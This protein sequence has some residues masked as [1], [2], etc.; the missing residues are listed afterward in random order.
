MGGEFFPLFLQRLEEH[1]DVGA[2][3]GCAGFV[4]LGEDDA[5]RDAVLAQ[6]F[7]ELHVY[8]L[9]LVA[10]VYQ[11]EQV[12]HLFPPQDIGRDDALQ[13]FLLFLSY[14]RIAVPREVHEKP[15][16]V[17]K[18][19]VDEQGLSRGG[20]G[21]GQFFMVGQHVDQAGFAYIG[22]PDERVFRVCRGWALV[23][24]GVADDKFCRF[25]FRHSL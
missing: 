1:G 2:E 9:W 25:D 24:P 10:G 23:H 16:L 11:D 3:Y 4:R 15:L 21:L 6:P 5:E 22:T 14:F 18:E 20:R 17:D 12:G 19:M 7:D 13:F 8:L